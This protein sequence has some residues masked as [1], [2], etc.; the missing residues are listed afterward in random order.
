MLHAATG[1]PRLLAVGA[2]LHRKLRDSNRVACGYASVGDVSTGQL[3]VRA[4]RVGGGCLC[5]GAGRQRTGSKCAARGS[6]C[7]M[8]TG[9]SPSS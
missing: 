7:Y 8:G 9:H 2:A 1:D 4:A 3:E 5:V 6:A